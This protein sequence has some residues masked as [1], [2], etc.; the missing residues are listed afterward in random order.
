MLTLNWFNY[1]LIRNCS[2]NKSPL[3]FNKKLWIGFVGVTTWKMMLVHSA[4]N[5]VDNS[6]YTYRCII[7]SCRKCLKVFNICHCKNTRHVDFETIHVTKEPREKH[8]LQKSSASS[9]KDLPN[10]N[11]IQVTRRDYNSSLFIRSK[12]NY[13]NYKRQQKLLYHSYDLSAHLCLKN[14]KDSP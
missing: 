10:V 13:K 1:C 7:S 5:I 6:N 8:W 14:C 3:T 4:K 12:W 11:C 9:I 2:K